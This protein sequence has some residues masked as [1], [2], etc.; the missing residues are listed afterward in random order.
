[1]FGAQGVVYLSLKL[2]V[3]ADLIRHPRKSLCFHRTK[4]RQGSKRRHFAYAGFSNPTLGMIRDLPFEVA[5]S[6][7]T[8]Q[9]APET[10]AQLEC[11]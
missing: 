5:N 3:S 8:K 10:K 4:R 7:E 6:S 2:R 9:L 1:M 11:G